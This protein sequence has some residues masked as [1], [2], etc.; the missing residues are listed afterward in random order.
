ML[1]LIRA[2]GFRVEFE[3]ALQYISDYVVPRAYLDGICVIRPPTEWKHKVVFPTDRL[4][5]LRPQQLLDRVVDSDGLS[6]ASVSADDP[7]VRYL[8]S[9]IVRIQSVVFDGRR[10]DASR[11]QS[12][13]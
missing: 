10:L 13:C 12:W 7:L 3:N 1:S 9:C 8:S 5:P 6:L 2:L 11:M 4:I